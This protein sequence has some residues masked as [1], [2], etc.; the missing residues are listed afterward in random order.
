MLAMSKNIKLKE[1]TKFENGE[2]KYAL[3]ISL[4]I[5]NN[6]SI[7]NEIRL[8]NEEIANW[9]KGKKIESILE[10]VIAYTAS[11]IYLSEIIINSKNWM[12]V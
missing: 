5:N 7:K 9:S 11:A 3:G 6:F 2:E 4:T 10:I 8:I 1:G 12:Y